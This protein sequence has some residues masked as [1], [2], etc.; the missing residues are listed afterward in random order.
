MAD[1]YQAYHLMKANGIPDENIIVMHYDDIANKEKNIYP[2]HVYNGPTGHVNNWQ[3]GQPDKSDRN[4]VLNN[5]IGPD[6]AA[7][8][9]DVKEG[10]CCGVI[11]GN[12]LDGHG[13]TGEN[14]SESWI[15]VKGDYYDI[16]N[17][18]GTSPKLNKYEI[19][20]IAKAGI[21]GCHNTIMNNKCNGAPAGGHFTV[22]TMKNC[23]NKVQ[24]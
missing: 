17:N 4:Q 6:V 22:N 19:H 24:G 11:K 5:H 8:C 13:E 10:S 23:G 16:Q 2:G 18:T 14:Y 3:G 1:V 12:Y 15:N 20:R 9:I 7:E 21:G